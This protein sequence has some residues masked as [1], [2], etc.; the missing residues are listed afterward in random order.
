[1]GG[2]HYEDCHE[3][4]PIRLREC[5]ADHVRT[6]VL[7]GRDMSDDPKDLSRDPK[8]YKYRV[9]EARR[10]LSGSVEK[11]FEELQ[12]NRIFAVLAQMQPTPIS[13]A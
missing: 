4:R 9:G 6:W 8:V 2:R 12:T 7:G 5:V 3:I 13:P 1:M 11:A 10:V